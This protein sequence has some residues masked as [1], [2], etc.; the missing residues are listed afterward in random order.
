MSKKLNGGGREQLSQVA[1]L[2]FKNCNLG[3]KT[4]I[5][6]PKQP[7]NPFKTAKRRERVGTL[8]VRLDFPVSTS[9]LRP[10]NSTTYVLET[11]QKG[12]RSPKFCVDWLAT[13]TNQEQAISWA[14]WLKT[15][16]RGHLVHPQPPTFCGFHPLELPKRTP[17]PPYV[18]PAGYGKLQA[19]AQTGGCP[20]GSTRSN[21]GKK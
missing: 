21:R 9:P 14:T 12:P 6:G 16:F 17:R 11:A 7:Q 3:P 2:G 20:I 1:D 19:Q 18:A 8:H 15:R 13:A 10:S 5:F 4:A